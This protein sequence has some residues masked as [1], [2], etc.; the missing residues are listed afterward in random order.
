MQ[1]YIGLT[2][3]CVHVQFSVHLVQFYKYALAEKELSLLNLIYKF[4]LR[5]LKLYMTKT[6][7]K[8]LTIGFNFV[9]DD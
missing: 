3:V 8:N 4:I 5:T 2:N 9:D 6:K 7:K 1:I